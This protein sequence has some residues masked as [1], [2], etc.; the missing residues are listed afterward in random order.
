MRRTAVALAAGL[1]LLAGCDAVDDLSGSAE[2]PTSAAGQPSEQTSSQAAQDDP[3]ALTTNVAKGQ[4]DVPV[5]TRVTV[6]VAD[7][8]LGDV[9]LTDGTSE[10]TGETADGVW[11]ASQLLEPDTSYT[12]K[13]RAV[14]SQ[15]GQ[16]RR[17]VRFHTV[18]LSLQQ[19]TY[20]SIAPLDGETVGIGM[21][22]IVAFDVPV[23][24]K[25]EFER[26]MTVTSQPAQEGSWNWLSDTEA[27]WRPAT[28]WQPG[29]EVSVAV[30]VNSLPAG[31]GVYGQTDRQVAFH[32]G[33]SHI[34]KV[35]AKTDR[36][37]VY[38]NKSLVKNFPIT[39]GKEGFTTRS[40]IK[41]I[42]EKFA[43][44]RM[45]SETIGIT[46][47]SDY[48]DLDDV[49][50]AMRLTYSGEFIHAA[51]WSVASQG[52][53]NVSHGCTGMSTADAKW[54]YDLSLRGDV[55]V[56]TG[57]NRP[58]DLTNGYGDWNESYADW[59]AGSALS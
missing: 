48:Y 7:G 47:G 55:V 42:M 30:D 16:A 35:N 57:T 5:D 22:V 1:V 14:G 43:K 44:R 32:V 34:Y 52:H 11:T 27:H 21:P 10:I 39:T 24:D 58:M 26:H 40:G 33:D 20:P 18:A 13:A 8:T 29:T 15:G 19:Q 59:Q 56:Y 41:V 12:L 3:V 49:Q 25:A 9:T 38:V 37:R 28:Y 54:L 31:N 4:S 46:S 51:P 2:G 6:E 23:T 53:A 17:T 50:W 45:R 36:M